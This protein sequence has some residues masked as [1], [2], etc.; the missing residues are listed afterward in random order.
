MRKLLLLVGLWCGTPPA[1]AAELAPVT[2]PNQAACGACPYETPRRKPFVMFET[3]AKAPSTCAS[4]QPCS[5]VP[6]RRKPFVLFRSDRQT[7]RTACHFESGCEECAR[8]RERKL[9]KLIGWLCYVPTRTPCAKQPTPCC[10]PPMYLF[11]TCCQP[12]CGAA[13]QSV[14]CSTGSGCRPAAACPTCS[15]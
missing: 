12:P 8:E 9:A 5:P 15:Y 11:F 13:V 10:V 14:G 4:C 2:Y 3:G 6:A 1:W 7:H